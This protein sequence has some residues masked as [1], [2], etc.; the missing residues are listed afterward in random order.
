MTTRT[1]PIFF[2]FLASF[3]V[4]ACG[5][6]SSVDGDAAQSEGAF[7]A[8]EEKGDPEDARQVEALETLIAGKEWS[9]GEMS[10]TLADRTSRR[11]T[12]KAGG[13]NVEGTWEVALQEGVAA[14]GFAVVVLKVSAGGQA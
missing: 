11:F 13:H 5:D 9:D 7:T 4:A 14:G 2:A 6:S 12:L 8:G 1:S 10:L 3:L